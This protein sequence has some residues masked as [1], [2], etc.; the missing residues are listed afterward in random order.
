M[1]NNNDTRIEKRTH[2]FRSYNSNVAHNDV[3]KTTIVPISGIWGIQRDA[4]I[5]I[6]NTLLIT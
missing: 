3:L 1:V 4:L 2:T 6:N 5:I